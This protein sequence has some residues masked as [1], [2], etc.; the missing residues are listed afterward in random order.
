MTDLTRK[1]RGAKQLGGALGVDRSAPDLSASRASI[2]NV[3]RFILRLLRSE[4]DRLAKDEAL[5]RYYFEA[6]FDPTL[7]EKERED[8]IANFLRQPP[9]VVLGYPRSSVTFPVIAI[10]LNEES[11]TQNAVGDFIG[12][13]LGEG[14]EGDPYADYVGAIFEAQ[15]GVYVYAE[16]PDVCLYLYHFVKMIVLGGKDWLLSQGVIEVSI[17]GGELAPQ[18]GYLPENMFCRTVNVKTVAPFVV[19][20]PALTD[21]RKARVVGLYQDDV[22]V[23]GVRGGVHSYPEGYPGGDY[24]GETTSWDER[25]GPAGGGSDDP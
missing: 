15:H 10:I 12:E 8:Y 22:V 7:P 2:V 18:E 14:E 19:P 3:E 9:A 6:V 17:S 23:D 5:L 1:A 24:N 4:V 25:D 13:T 11:E 21:A 16:H 20:R